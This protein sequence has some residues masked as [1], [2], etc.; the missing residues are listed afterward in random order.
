MPA[1]TRRPCGPYPSDTML[2]PLAAIVFAN[3]AC[4]AQPGNAVTPDRIFASDFGGEPHALHGITAAHNAERARVGAAPLLWDERIAASAQA[5]AN[6]CVDRDHDGMIDHNPERSKGF[7]WYVGENIFATSGNA[8]PREAVKDWA[9]EARNY[10]A[11]RNRCAPGKV[12]GH[13]TQLVWSESL[14]LGC[15]V[16][17]CPK[18]KLRNSIVC[19]YAPGGNYP[20]QRPYRPRTSSP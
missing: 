17:R 7:A 5:W 9:A 20:D 11:A 18:L 3:I 12:C 6:Q 1:R 19:D 4:A 14:R 8:T 10:D 2:R 16:S 15:A 13:Y